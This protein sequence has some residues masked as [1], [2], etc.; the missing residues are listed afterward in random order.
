MKLQSVPETYRTADWYLIN[1]DVYHKQGDGPAA[2]AAWQEA[3]N[4][5]PH[6]PDSYRRSGAILYFAR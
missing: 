4:R 6:N 5:D 2:L 3:I 1:G